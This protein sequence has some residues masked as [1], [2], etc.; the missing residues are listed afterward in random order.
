M[1]LSNYPT[2][3][4]ALALDFANSGKADIISNYNT[5]NQYV[6]HTT[7]DKNGYIRVCDRGEARI[8]YDPETK[9][10]QGLLS[11]MGIWNWAPNQL[12]QFRD[13]AGN[14]ANFVGW[15]GQLD[16]TTQTGGTATR[17][18]NYK[19]PRGIINDCPRYLEGTATPTNTNVRIL[20]GDFLP[21][22]AQGGSGL[23]Q[24]EI[25]VSI[26]VKIDPDGQT[27]SD[28]RRKMELW[29]S[30]ANNTSA[31]KSITAKINWEFAN[32]DST[33]DTPTTTQQFQDA[34]LISQFQHKY[35]NGWW[36]LGFTV[37]PES[38]ADTFMRMHYRFTGKG[39]DD[40]YTGDNFAW[41]VWGPQIERNIGVGKS[42]GPSTLTINMSTSIT[43]GGFISPQ[44][45]TPI[46]R[47]TD[48]LAMLTF[49]A[50]RDRNTQNRGFFNRYEYTWA[51]KI[52]SD[53]S[54]TSE[55]SFPRIMALRPSQGGAGQSDMQWEWF[56]NTT[57]LIT[58]AIIGPGNTGS[59]GQDYVLDSEYVNGRNYN[60][61][62]SQ[63]FDKSVYGTT[64]QYRNAV[65][66]GDEPAEEVTG[67]VIPTPSQYPVGIVNDFA[68]VNELCF[69]SLK[70]F[71]PCIRIFIK[72]V[73]YWPSSVT[74]AQAVK[75]AE[76]L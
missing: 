34:T 65:K 70:G 16:C 55:A 27:S 53:T 1:A 33:N 28:P 18:H 6:Y 25:T 36:R 11:E 14:L 12:M 59:N 38:G 64:N 54:I 29:L 67:Q 5:F 37:K 21:S 39:T 3:S 52:R 22:A 47:N 60:L 58:S 32:G 17:T 49:D 2:Q 41:Y 24:G 74:K 23:T 56:T 73:K 26:F 19:S 15:A 4:P 43:A 68:T 75:I 30:G 10:C 13:P 20:Y 57:N 66:Q 45:W 44:L 42:F 62:T 63:N 48:Q 69:G 8:Y 76:T 71:D 9:E 7:V 72:A 35:P 61:V 50:P 46:A 40:R 31:G 51:L